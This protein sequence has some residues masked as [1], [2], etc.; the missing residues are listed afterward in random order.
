MTKSRVSSEVGDRWKGEKTASR[1]QF[2]A[3]KVSVRQQ[4]EYS[5]SQFEF[6]T[7]LEKLDTNRNKRLQFFQNFPFFRSPFDQVISPLKK[8]WFFIQNAY[9]KNAGIKL[10]TYPSSQSTSIEF[11]IPVTMLSPK[12]GKIFLVKSFDNRL[13]IWDNIISSLATKEF[14][15][16]DYYLGNV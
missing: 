15:F 12:N 16:K 10:V 4:L 8:C 1:C 5:L 11:Q 3:S 14:L 6:R 13:Y 2:N 7:E 9:K